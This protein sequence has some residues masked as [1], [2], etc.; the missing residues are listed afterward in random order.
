MEIDNVIGKRINKDL[1]SGHL[2]NFND[3]EF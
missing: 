2:L 1:A 3:L